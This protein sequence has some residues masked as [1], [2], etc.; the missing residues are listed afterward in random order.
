MVRTSWR[1]LNATRDH[2]W[3][4]D[5]FSE[6]LDGELSPRQTIRLE[7][8]AA[9]CPDCARLVATLQALLIA[10]PLLRLPP[11]AALAIGERTTELVRAQ[12]EEWT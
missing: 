6:Y 12:M 1:R 4:R 11:A 7:A 2:R 8:H 10:L 3:A 9:L 5:R